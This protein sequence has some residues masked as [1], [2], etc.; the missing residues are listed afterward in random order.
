MANISIISEQIF[1]RCWKFIIQ[2]HL[3][4]GFKQ[5]SQDSRL[6]WVLEGRRR[7]GKPKET[8]RR[9]TGRGRKASGF[10][11]W[12]EATV[13]ALDPWPC[14]MAKESHGPAL[15]T[16]RIMAKVLMIIARNFIDT[17]NV[18]DEPYK[19]NLYIIFLFCFGGWSIERVRIVG[20]SPWTGP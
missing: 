5:T 12:S 19:W 15:N 8:W 7:R 20:G 16:P 2:P 14:Y 11:S 3:Q 9:T 6:T 1:W 18:L 13:A 4:N 17:I 10:I